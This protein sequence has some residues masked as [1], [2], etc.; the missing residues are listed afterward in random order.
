MAFLHFIAKDLVWSYLVHVSDAVNGFE[1]LFFSGASFFF[2]IMEANFVFPDHVVF[3][4]VF[5]F[6]G[7]TIHSYDELIKS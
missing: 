4:A 3:A 7:V 5:N 6:L 1:L 2:E